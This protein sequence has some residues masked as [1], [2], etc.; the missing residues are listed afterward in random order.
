M[1]NFFKK[2][3]VFTLA[4]VVVLS[5]TCGAFAASFWSNPDPEDKIE[6]AAENFA[7][8][9]E[10]LVENTGDDYDQNADNYPDNPD[11]VNYMENVFTYGG[12]FMSGFKA[13]FTK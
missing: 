4:L 5:C 12:N 11:P 13:L 6:A 3:G 2:V 1:K 10:V 7:D 8:Q 9:L